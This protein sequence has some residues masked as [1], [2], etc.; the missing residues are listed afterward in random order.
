MPPGR[1]RNYMWRVATVLVPCGCRGPRPLFCVFHDGAR[2]GISMSMFDPRGCF[3]ERSVASRD[4]GR[5]AG[6]EEREF[7]ML[8]EHV[9]VGSVDRC[10][11]APFPA[12]QRKSGKSKETGFRLFMIQ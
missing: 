11:H 8:L 5:P 4:R 10:D 12:Y 7:D 2:H 6:V 9:C 1:F 3:L